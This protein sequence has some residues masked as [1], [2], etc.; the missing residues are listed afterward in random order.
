MRTSPD[1]PFWWK[2]WLRLPSLREFW[3]RPRP[4]RPRGRHERG[5]YEVLSERY[6]EFTAMNLD[7]F[8]GTDDQKMASALAALL[9]RAPVDPG[10]VA[11]GR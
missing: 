3:Q 5:G 11:E 9:T 7:S 10:D 8:A 1:P 6:P 4:V 2:P